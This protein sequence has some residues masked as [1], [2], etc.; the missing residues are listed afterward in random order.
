MIAP[1]FQALNITDVEIPKDGMR[2]SRFLEILDREI[3]RTGESE[4]ADEAL[5]QK[6]MNL[7]ALKKR[8]QKNSK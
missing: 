7:F 6:R 2:V 3:I 4:V 8:V 1:A 5:I